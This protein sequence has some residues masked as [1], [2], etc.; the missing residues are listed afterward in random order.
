MDATKC[1]GRNAGHAA[2]AKTLTKCAADFTATPRAAGTFPARHNT[3]TAEVLS[4][5]IKGENLTG[6]DAV[7]CANTTRL[8]AFINYLGETY[9]WTIDRVDIDVGTNDGRVAVISAY[10]LP[11]ATIRRAFDA[12]ALEFCRSVMVA[13]AK[14]RKLASKVKADAEK[15]NAA[16]AAVRFNPNQGVLFSGDAANGEI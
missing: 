4:R 10:Y 15:R 3:V 13:R 5:L 7:F 11:R 12:G 1:N 6:M 16:R 14:R 2:P 9:N 8:A